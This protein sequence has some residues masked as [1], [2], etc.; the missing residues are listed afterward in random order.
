[1]KRLTALKS[2]L[3]IVAM[4]Q[5]SGLTPPSVTAA[6]AHEGRDKRHRREAARL[7][8]QLAAAVQARR[9]H[10]KAAVE[11]ER[12]QLLAVGGPGLGGRS[13]GGGGTSGNAADGRSDVDEAREITRTLNRWV[14]C[15]H[16]NTKTRPNQ[17][18]A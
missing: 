2:A 17:T 10:T 3:D 11:R 6:A 4:D 15:A 9:A 1:M 7:T 12:D 16:E 5:G 18:R 13:G 8:E 14:F